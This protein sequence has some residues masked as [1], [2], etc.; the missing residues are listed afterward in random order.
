MW[1]EA[2]FDEKGR[3]KQARLR[4]CS[5]AGWPA[6]CYLSDFAAG[7]P[8]MARFRTEEPRCWHRRRRPLLEAPAADPALAS[9]YSK[10]L[11]ADAATAVDTAYKKG[12]PVRDR[13]FPTRPSNGWGNTYNVTIDA[14]GKELL[15]AGRVS[16]PS[17]HLRHQ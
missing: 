16:K 13:R 7:S 10:A 2:S 8:C 15:A 17:A 14:Y 11:L 3:L 5:V 12:R 4:D 9:D 6:G 1:P